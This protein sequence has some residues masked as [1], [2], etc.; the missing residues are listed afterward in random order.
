MEFSMKLYKKFI[1]F[2]LLM[3]SLPLMAAPIQ[4][5][6]EQG[7]NGHWY[8]I[9][10]FDGTF[11]DAIQH[12]AKSNGFLASITTEAESQFI[13]QRL[14]DVTCVSDFCQTNHPDGF[15][16]G[17]QQVDTS[18]V[19]AG[20]KWINPAEAF[21]YTNWSE[22]EPNDYQGKQEDCIALT[23]LRGWNDTSCENVLTGY[24]IEYDKLIQWRVE[25]G[26]NGHWYQLIKEP[27]SWEQAKQAANQSRLNGLTGYL[28]TINS[29]GEYK[30]LKKLF[31]E[32]NNLLIT[33]NDFITLYSICRGSILCSRYVQSNFIWLGGVVNEQNQWQ[34]YTGELWEYTPFDTRSDSYNK[35]LMYGYLYDPMSL[36][37]GPNISGYLVEYG[38]ITPQTPEIVYQLGFDEGVTS[39]QQNPHSCGLEKNCKPVIYQAHIEKIILPQVKKHDKTKTSKIELTTSF[40]TENRLLFITDNETEINISVPTKIN[41]KIPYEQGFNAAQLSCYQNPESCNINQTCELTQLDETGLLHIPVVSI[42]INDKTFSYQVK[43]RQRA[44]DSSIFDFVDATYLGD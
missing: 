25:D 8:D 27:L 44:D 5:Q 11:Q 26:G 2:I 19:D 13:N 4:W 43:L 24:V 1:I 36:S 17:G 37:I 14:I 33:G 18:S 29:E 3:I 12:A 16:L 21:S 38:E 31:F 35:Y 9:V 10:F 23:W 39:C 40:T 7:G 15:W 20:W 41:S 22:N 34:W 42:P 28:A 30:I 32:A 6:V